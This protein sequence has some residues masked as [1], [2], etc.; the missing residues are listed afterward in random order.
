[1][2]KIVV[3]NNQECNIKYFYYSNGRK[4]MFLINIK[5]KKQI[6]VCTLNIDNYTFEKNEVIIKNYDSNSG[7][8]EILHNANILKYTKK[9]IPIGYNYGLIC[10]LT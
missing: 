10:K 2:K 3:W 1:M 5:T 7:M 8:Y 4:G 6:A 9:R